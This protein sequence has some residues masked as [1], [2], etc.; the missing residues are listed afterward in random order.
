MNDF[1]TSS[2][3][4]VNHSNED[5]YLHKN[6]MNGS[7][8]QHPILVNGINRNSSSSSL[9]KY[10]NK[11]KDIKSKKR[12][13]KNEEHDGKSSSN[14]ISSSSSLLVSTSGS[15]KSSSN[16]KKEFVQHSNSNFMSYNKGAVNGRSE[17]QEVLLCKARIPAKKR[18]R[19]Y[20]ATID[21][22]QAQKHQMQEEMIMDNA[23]PSQ[24]NKSPRTKSKNKSSSRRS[25]SSSTNSL[26]TNEIPEEDVQQVK[27]QRSNDEERKDAIV[28]PPTPVPV[29]L[30]QF[31]MNNLAPSNPSTKQSYNFDFSSFVPSQ[32]NQQN[33]LPNATRA[34]LPIMN[35]GISNNNDS[36]EKKRLSLGSA[37]SCSPSSEQQQP[38]RESEKIS[39]P[40]VSSVATNGS[41]SSSTKKSKNKVDK[42]HL[43]KGK[44]TV[45]YYSCIKT[46]FLT[47]LFS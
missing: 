40:T 34:S 39:S 37:A 22:Q 27:R 47:L 25:Y 21:Q 6:G 35:N 20:F 42:S 44:W 5:N 18:H 4:G 38:I 33:M 31:A 2:S 41:N 28:T 1:K 43:R 29:N 7:S 36:N 32:Q 14:S 12:S 13:S 45:S 10:V 30:P 17:E 24:G 46:H 3:G 26:T 9:P 16:K 8:D 23:S 15:T 19:L 11:K